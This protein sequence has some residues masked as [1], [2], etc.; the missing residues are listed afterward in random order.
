MEIIIRT[1]QVEPIAHPSGAAAAD[2]AQPGPATGVEQSA[3]AGA[4]DAGPAP[5]PPAQAGASLVNVGAEEHHLAPGGRP[6]LS[7]GAAPAGHGQ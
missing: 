1:E 3:T 6:D 5:A 2:T 7:A 4:I